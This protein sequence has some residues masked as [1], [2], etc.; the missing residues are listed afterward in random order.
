[1]QQVTPLTSSKTSTLDQ[2]AFS[3]IEITLVIGIMLAIASMI[4]YSVGSLGDWKA[5]RIA[6]EDLKAV[7]VAQKGYLADHPRALPA[8]FTEANIIK[9][10]PSSLTEMPTGISL[11]DQDLTLDY[12]ILPPVF[13]LG[14]NTYDASDSKSD[15]LWDVGGLQ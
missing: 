2:R 5:G 15:G 8:N 6:A 9:Y 7:F 1:M 3:L 14:T 11:D 13:K 12:R 10:L 4:T